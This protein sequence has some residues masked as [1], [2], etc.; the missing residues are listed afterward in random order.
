MKIHILGPSGSGTST[1]GETISKKYNFP[2]FD[3][4]NFFWEQTDPPFLKKRIKKD[5][6]Q[7]LKRELNKNDSWVLSGSIIGWGDF[8]K[9]RL[10]LVIYLYIE[11]AIRIHRLIDRERVRY[12]NRIDP[13]ND[14]YKIHIEFIEWA[15]NYERDNMNMR[16]RK[17][18]NE[19]MKDLKCK[20]IKIEEEMSL[21][22]EMEIVS[23][24]IDLL[25]IKKRQKIIKI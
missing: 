19:W 2:W 14:M 6:V 10:D 11:P 1:L 8:I 4:D 9:K 13:G 21:Q 22:K 12:G 24:E 15:R 7:F 16:S 17:S 18:E 20:I 23:K 25:L 3:S 5:R